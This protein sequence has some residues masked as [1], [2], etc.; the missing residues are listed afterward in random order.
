[1]KYRKSDCVEKYRKSLNEM[2][3]LPERSILRKI[4]DLEEAG[5]IVKTLGKKFSLDSLL[6]H[7]TSEFGWKFERAAVTARLIMPMSTRI[8][9]LT[10][11]SLGYSDCLESNEITFRSP[12]CTES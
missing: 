11:K 9:C 6:Q 3:T 10:L 7:M 5:Y 1:V 12:E 4:V 2:V 8:L